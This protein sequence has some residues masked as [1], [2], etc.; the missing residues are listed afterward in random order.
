M[1]KCLAVHK[2]CFCRSEQ[3]LREFSHFERRAGKRIIKWRS[4]QS[5]L[6]IS[7]P[8]SNENKKRLVISG[9]RFLL[10]TCNQFPAP[11]IR[12]RDQW[13]PRI[14]CRDSLTARQCGGG[15]TITY[16][17]SIN[18][19]SIK[20]EGYRILFRLQRPTGSPKV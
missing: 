1:H 20:S 15:S 16:R 17:P 19:R 10:F 3:I 18:R 11:Q 2:W 8:S 14:T 5:V 12:S 4:N 6:L 13:Q 7:S 9:S